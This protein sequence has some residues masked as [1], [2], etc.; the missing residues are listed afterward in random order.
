L[1]Q[2]ALRF[3]DGVALPM[4]LVAGLARTGVSVRV[5]CGCSG[6]GR[7]RG[8]GSG[9]GWQWLLGKHAGDT[10]SET[11]RMDRQDTRYL[12]ASKQL[13]Y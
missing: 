13:Q 3:D 1:G 4:V 8:R 10:L 9:N 12:I 7:G 5:L 11:E 2:V 6:R